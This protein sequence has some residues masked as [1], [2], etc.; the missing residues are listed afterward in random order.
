M[1]EKY[2]TPEVS[3]VSMASQQSNAAFDFDEFLVPGAREQGNDTLSG[4]SVPVKVRE[5]Y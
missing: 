3:L 5:D 1:K 4:Y 2:L